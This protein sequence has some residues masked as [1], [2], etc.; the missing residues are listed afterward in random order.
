MLSEPWGR[1]AAVTLASLSLVLQRLLQQRAQPPAAPLE[2]GHGAPTDGQ[3][4]EDG[5]REVRP[6][7]GEDG[8]NRAPGRLWACRGGWWEEAVSIAGAQLDCAL[9]WPSVP[10]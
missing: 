1:H 10:L 6:G 8:V 9:L 2:A 3:R 7:C 5:H 4:G